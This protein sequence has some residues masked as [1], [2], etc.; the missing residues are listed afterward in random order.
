MA[1]EPSSGSIFTL[2]L[3]ELNGKECAQKPQI[4]D[5]FNSISTIKNKEIGQWPQEDYLNYYEVDLVSQSEANLFRFVFLTRNLKQ[6][7][8]GLG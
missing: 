5:T 1:E 2:Q 6:K 8:E 7:G 4:F 3:K